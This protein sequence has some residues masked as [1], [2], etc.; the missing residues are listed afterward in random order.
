[1]I[2]TSSLRAL[3]ARHIASGGYA[4]GAVIAA[5][6]GETVLEVYAGTA[7]PGLEAGRG[8]LWPIAS[9]SKMYAV[10]AAMRLVEVGEL[11]LNLPVNLALPQFTGDGREQIRVRHLLTHTSGLIYE[12][13]EMEARLMALTPFE[14]LLEEA[15]RAPLLF[16]PGTS[17]SYADYN[18]LI[19]GRV[20]EVVT[21]R[22]LPDLVRELV[23][24][25]MGLRDTYFPT[26]QNQDS[27][28]ARV[29][30]VMAEGTDGAMYNS[31]Y[32]RGLPHPAF[33]VT[34]T[35]RDALRFVQHFAPHGPR[36]LGD[37]TVRAMTKDQTG[38]LHGV[39]P[40]VKG[41]DTTAPM[42]WGLGWALQTQHTPALLCELAGFQ[43]FGH[44]GASGCQV[45]VDPESQIS[46]GVFTNAHLRAGREPW[47][48]RLQRLMNHAYALVSSHNPQSSSHELEST[49]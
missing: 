22:T 16:K 2:D 6:R 42:P 48:A 5:H 38:L 31:R 25:P 23:L 17:L 37:A 19:L 27:R 26:P 7:A 12:S 1:M 20:L 28:V 3:M 24:E 14:D 45:F 44:G 29:Q 15:Y 46:L 40:S 43:T 10:T 21:G 33:A 49:H 35:A 9:I 32:A 11:T 30:H 34:A 36:V 41:Y 13:P 8:V 4:G 39:H 18:T 47:Y